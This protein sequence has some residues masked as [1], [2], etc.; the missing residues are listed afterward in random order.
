MEWIK[1]MLLSYYN[2]KSPKRVT[3]KLGR[4]GGQSQ[5]NHK[6][7]NLTSFFLIKPSDSN[8]QQPRKGLESKQ[9]DSELLRV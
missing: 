9:C 2:N 8:V 6:A 1:F 5:N 7:T 3:D 4:G